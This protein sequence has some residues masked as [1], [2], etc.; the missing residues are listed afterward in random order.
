MCGAYG[1]SYTDKKDLYDRFNVVNDL[2]DL[3]PRYNMH[4]WSTHPVIISHSP[5][6][7]TWMYWNLIPKQAK[8]RDEYKAYSLFNAKK[9]KLLHSG[10]WT[11][12][13]RQQQRCLIPATHFFE[14][15]KIHYPKGKHPWYGFLLKD[16][17]LFAIAGIY[18]VWTDPRTGTEVFSYAMVTV[19]P[20]AVVGEVHARM[21]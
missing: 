13:F 5:N 1:L 19:E 3:R 12:P 18:D 9:E 17:G 15:D 2:A 16:R 8:T 21:P 10:F 11:R 7:I 14:P 20:D 6:Q 4:P